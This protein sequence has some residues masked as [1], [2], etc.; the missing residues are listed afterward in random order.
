MKKIIL[1]L[2]WYEGMLQDSVFHHPTIYMVTTK[3]G[4]SQRQVHN[5]NQLLINEFFQFITKDDSCPV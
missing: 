5:T 3:G 4:Y 2:L 1:C